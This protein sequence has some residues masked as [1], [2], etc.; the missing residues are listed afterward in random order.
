VRATLH[1]ALEI[2]SKDLYSRE[3]HFVLE[4]VQNADD[5]RYA[6]G[7]S[8]ELTFTLMPEC[9]TVRNNEVGFSADNV[10]ALCTVGDSTKAQNGTCQWA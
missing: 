4:L 9:V 3:T 7:V 8:P 10:R 1:R 2:V 5:N 6:P